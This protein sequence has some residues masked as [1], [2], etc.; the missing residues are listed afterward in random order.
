MLG[1]AM[2][3]ATV[4]ISGFDLSYSLEDQGLFGRLGF[5]LVDWGLGLGLKA[6]ILALVSVV[7]KF[8]A[9]VSKSSALYLVVLLA[10]LYVLL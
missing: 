1:S 6:K 5:G 7:S 8:L 4:N 10:S 3:M 2:A 9:L